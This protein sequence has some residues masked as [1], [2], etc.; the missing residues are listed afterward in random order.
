M[1][2]LFLAIA[3]LLGGLLLFSACSNDEGSVGDELLGTSKINIS[4]IE[5]STISITNT[6]DTESDLSN[7]SKALLGTL[8]DEVFGKTR[9]GVAFQVRLTGNVKFDRA[10]IDSVKLFLAYDGFYGKD[11]LKMQNAKVYLLNDDIQSAKIYNA[12]FQ[13]ASILG[14]EVGHKEFNKE[15]ASD[16][17]YLKSKIKGKETEDSIKDSKKQVDTILRHLTIPLDNEKVGQLILDA[18]KDVFKSGTD[19]IRFFKG[20]YVNTDDISGVEG[21]VYSFNVYGS[22]LRLYY[23]NHAILSSGK[24]TIYEAS[25]I[26]PITDNSARFNLPEFTQNTEILSSENSIYLQGIHGTKGK[27]EIPELS[28]WKDSTRVSINSAELVFKI[29]TTEA[30]VKKYQLPYRL[31]LV[32]VDKKGKKTPIRYASSQSGIPVPT[33]FLDVKNRI[34]TFQISDLLQDIV[35]NKKDFDYFELSTGNIELRQNGNYPGDAKNSAARVVLH[36]TGANK[37]MLKVTYTKY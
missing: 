31:E 1:K 7:I 18:P 28:S 14:E 9:S 26:L 24:D 8:N 21:A 17:I 12:A 5:D 10:T 16:T 19:F 35:D 37:P 13:I 32:M 29:A 25:Y 22:F 11:S 23:K 15:L 3:L 20:L 2:N 34:Y 27:I 30:E 33:G 36:K 4:Y 6:K